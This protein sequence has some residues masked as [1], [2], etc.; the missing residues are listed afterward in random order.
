ML[1]VLSD[2]HNELGSQYYPLPSA[3]EAADAVILAGD[4]DSHTRGI[5]WARN[6]FMGK[7]VIMIAGNHEFYGAEIHGMIAQMRKVAAA[8]DV[9]FLE[10]DEWIDREHNVRFLGCSLWTDLQLYGGADYGRAIHDAKRFMNDFT[11]IRMAPAA[12]F[13]PEDS[14]RMHKQSRAW[15][16]QNIARPFAGKTVVVTHHL[17]SVRL[18]AP[19]FAG[20]ALNPAFASNLDHLVEM[21]DLW[22]CGHTH[23]AADI[24]IGKC[25]V[26]VNPRGYV[27]EGYDGSSRYTE[28]TGWREDLVVEI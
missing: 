28:E 3:V 22:I 17:P 25:R 9:F 24:Q 23:S 2:L 15:L 13:S 4:I 16:E 20:D 5:T 12:W 14:V 26:V 27:R 18:V 10:N 6:A 1:L 8:C 7:R 21:A 19:E 11:R